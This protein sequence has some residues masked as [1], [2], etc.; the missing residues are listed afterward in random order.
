M[1]RNKFLWLLF[2]MFIGI[3]SLKAQTLDETV[4][5]FDEYLGFVK[6]FHP[7]VK[8]VKLVVDE[9]Q[10][11]LMKARGA[12]DP[13]ME[14]DF[15]RKNFKNTEYYDKLNAAF[16]IPTWYGIELKASFEEAD[17][18]YLNPES[19]FPE[20]GLY[21][22]GVSFSVAQGFLIN[23]RMA[24]LKQA[25]LF[26]EQAKSD[27]DILVNTIL[28]DAALVYFNWLQAYN[29][30]KIFEDFLTNASIRFE[31]VKRNVEVGE[32]A[33]IDSVEAR[34][35]VNDRKLNVE[36]S[37]LKLLKTKLELSTYLWLENNIPVELQEGIIPDI[38]SEFVV[39]ATL[40]IDNLTVTDFQVESHPNLQSLQFK[41]ESLHIEKRLKANMLLPRIDLQYNFLSETPD[42]LSTYNTSALK[43]GVN[44]SFPLFLRKERGD[45]KLAKVKLQDVQ[46]NITSTKLTLQNKIAAI[47]RELESYVV[48]YKL[49]MDVL[50]DYERMLTAEERKFAVGESSL[51]FVNNRERKLIDAKLKAAELQKNFLSTKALMFNNLAINPEF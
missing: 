10:A 44:I 50:S 14:V 41:Y 39:D 20:A 33:A 26:R 21:S 29:E 2:T 8:Q 46:Y 42:V 3:C 24:A 27:R 43:S 13:K 37:R 28:Y 12:F 5:R 31:G 30:T 25:K 49:V 6:E 4:L 1:R 22:A 15:I 17:G 48:Q 45:F 38:S 35:V 23:E 7:I 16:K 51:F 19:N 9:S 32:V 36:K 47:K 34:I 40:N 11:K 18:V